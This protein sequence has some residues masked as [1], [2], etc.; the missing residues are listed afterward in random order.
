MA[1]IWKAEES[2]VQ[3]MKDLIAQYHPHLALL[4]E[5]IAVVF[6]EKSSKVGDA[7]VI[8]KTSKA[9]PL[10]G[11]LGDTSWKFIITLAADAWSNMTDKERLALLDHHLCY[12][13]VKEDK[14]GN[15]KCYIK[16]PDVSFFEGEVERHGFWR[17]S[18]DVPDPDDIQKMFG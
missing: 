7:D 10:L 13:G 3:S 18:G 2:I 9:T 16:V 14:D 6:K 11:V 5:E 8:G 1:D 4:S 17:T 15:L 12:C